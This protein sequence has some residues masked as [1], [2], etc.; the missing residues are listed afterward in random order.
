MLPEAA[1]V[2]IVGA[3]PAGLAAAIT[4]RR[5]G[6]QKLVVVE[7]EAEAGG[8]PRLCHHSGFGWRDL[9]RLLS[10]PSYA[11]RYR[12]AAGRLDIALHTETTITGWH[13]PGL[14]SYSG[15]AGPGRL[16]ARAV[17]L[18]TGC[19]ERPRAA[20]LVPGSRPQGIFT[21]GSLQQFVYGHGLPVG[22]RAVI[23][24]AELV[25]LS[26]LM[27]L[28][29]AGVAVVA[30]LSE[31]PAHQI[32][33]PYH[34]APFFLLDRLGRAPLLMGVQV[35]RILGQRRVEG[36]EI[37]H[38]ASGRLE[39]LLCDTLVFSGDWIPEHEMARLGGLRLDPGTQGPLVDPGFRTSRRGVF[40][41]GNLLRGA[42]T[43]DNCAREGQAAASQILRFL[44]AE[45]WPDHEIALRVEPP[46][47]WVFPNALRWPATAG[48]HSL[49]FR[50]AELLAR[51]GVQVM[52]NGHVLHEQHFP[53]LVPN[54][55]MALSA[56]WLP[57]VDPAGGEVCLRI[58]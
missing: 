2:L 16:R 56:R 54:V 35:S 32:Y 25:S 45:R 5:Q 15:P 12:E 11:R 48:L 1:D 4:L 37:T 27:T 30:M 28:R 50:A 8:I 36:L 44:H 38:L 22:R 41:A 9:R 19:R 10:G 26:A 34:P 3:G 58:G 7:R 46:L 18:A 51:V 47:R 43:A 33:P 39:T 42:E 29:H 52:Q 24:G 6:L 53:T 20:R 13:G 40:A 57:A 17:L 21:T 31:L 23:I 55:S 14:L 49:A